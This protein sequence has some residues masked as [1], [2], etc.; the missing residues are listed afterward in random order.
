MLSTAFL[1]A[2]S[3]VVGQAEQQEVTIPKEAMKALEDSVG[4][5]VGE[6]KWN[7]DA[8]EAVFEGEWAPGKLCVKVTG[9]ARI[10]ESKYT[11]N[12]I[13]G[14]DSATGEVVH[15]SHVAPD[16]GIEVVRYKTTDGKTFSG[17]YTYRSGATKSKSKVAGEIGEKATIWRFYDKVENGEEIEGETILTFRRE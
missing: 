10:G 4:R 12:G 13:V 15:W 1:L 3:M 2:T 14:W 16:A 6:G 8:Y 11:L 7:G 9:V 5:S 17:T